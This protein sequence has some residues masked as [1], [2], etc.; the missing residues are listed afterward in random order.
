MDRKRWIIAAALVLAAGLGYLGFS[1]IQSGDVQAQGSTEDT[2]VARRDTLE[3]L[4]EASGNLE[5]QEEATL[6][7]LSSE[8]VAEILVEEGDAVEA[9]EALARLKTTDLELAVA[10]AQVSL[11]QAQVELEQTVNGAREEE[12]AASEAQLRNAQANYSDLKTGSTPEE[13]DKAKAELD[14]ADSALRSAQTAYDRAGGGWDASVEISDQA[15]NLWQA[16]AAYKQA[17]ASYEMALNGATQEE[18]WASWAQV[19]QSQ[20]QLDQ[21]KNG[22]TPEELESAQVAVEKAEATLAQANLNLERAT[23]K[24]PMDGI[25]TEIAI[26]E[27]EYVSSGQDAITV[28]VLEPLE[29]E[30]D[31]DETDIAPVQ[32]GQEVNISLDALPDITLLGKVINIAATADTSSGV[33][34]YPVTIQ[35]TETPENLSVRPGMTVEVEIIVTRQEDALIVPLRAIQSEARKTYVDRIVGDDVERVEVELGVMTSSEVEILSG[36]EEGDVVRVSTAT[37]DTPAGGPP[38]GGM[39]GGG[40]PGGGAPGGRP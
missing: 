3:M 19:E 4:V 32:V 6:A 27:G 38:M 21:L 37:A 1:R 5:A 35:L 40:G 20:A 2:A 7:F 10:N 31:V 16:Q 33:V 12:I 28:S 29:V 11:S 15:S 14:L 22:A 26:E 17:Q 8:R 36:I 13:I 39:P 23:L 34:L 25:V 18:L 24:A 9:G 30:I